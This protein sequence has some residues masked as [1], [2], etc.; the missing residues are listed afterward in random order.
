MYLLFLLN[1]HTSS[2]GFKFLHVCLYSFLFEFVVVL[3]LA[4][5]RIGVHSA[6]TYNL[7]HDTMV[8]GL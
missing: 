6:A 2:A 4:G 7:S 5:F 8:F 3:V 1:K